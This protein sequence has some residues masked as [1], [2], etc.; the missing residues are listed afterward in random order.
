[1]DQPRVERA[2]RMAYDGDGVPVRL[3]LTL[4]AKNLLV[5]EFPL[6]E[7]GVK[8]VDGRWCY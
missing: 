3:E 2:S 6:A 5:E 1:M 7:T 4:R 8:E